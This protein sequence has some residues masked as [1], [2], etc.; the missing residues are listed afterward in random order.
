MQIK[1]ANAT[2]RSGNARLQGQRPSQGCAFDAR[3]RL[4]SPAAASRH[5]FDQDLAQL[6]FD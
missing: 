6:I 1:I 5:L 3:R 4:I 2:R